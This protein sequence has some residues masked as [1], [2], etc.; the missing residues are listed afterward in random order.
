MSLPQPPT[1][2]CGHA[3]Q[4]LYAD[5]PE[6]PFQLVC[7]KCERDEL[8]RQLSNVVNP[9]NGHHCGE[10][11]AEIIALKRQLD[12]ARRLTAS[13][14]QNIY[15]RQATIVLNEALKEKP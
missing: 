2:P 12:Q 14:P 10:S 1:T 15:C 11:E 13:D 4:F 7:M 3:I 9:D 8:K 6:N 5:Q